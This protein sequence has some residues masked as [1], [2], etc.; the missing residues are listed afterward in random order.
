[1]WNQS[2]EKPLGECEITLINP[3]NRRHYKVTFLVIVKNHKPIL[4]KLI[5][6]KMGLIT[7]NYENFLVANV[8]EATRVEGRL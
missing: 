8:T 2:K 7:I 4:G 6:E 5:S 1:M 3:K